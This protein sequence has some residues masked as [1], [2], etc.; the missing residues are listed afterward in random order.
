MPAKRIRWPA[1]LALRMELSRLSAMLILC[2]DQSIPLH[3]HRM[4]RWVTEIRY[5]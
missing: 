2:P 1:S 3:R 4:A 5:S